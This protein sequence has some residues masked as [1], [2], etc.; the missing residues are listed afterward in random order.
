GALTLRQEG[1]KDWEAEF[2]GH[3][4]D[5]DLSD[6]VNRRFP[7]HRL[8]GK[9][10]LAVDSARWGERPGQ[11][12]G[13]VEARGELTAGP[14]VIGLGLIQ[15]LCTEMHFRK[16]PRVGRIASAG[17]VDLDFRALAFRFAITPDGEI[18]ITGGLGNES[19][20]G[21]VVVNST[22]P[23]AFAPQGASN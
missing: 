20:D 7:S 11:G 14:G 18:R 19:A 22:A 12:F 6:L 21:A 10:R 15:A 16:G 8:S 17:L 3:L 5:I 1:S 13:W 23:L 4:L 9:A 2:Q